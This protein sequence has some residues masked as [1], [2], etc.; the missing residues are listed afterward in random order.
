[1]AGA[2]PVHR[3]RWA[4]SSAGAESSGL[5]S[6]EKSKPTQAEEKMASDDLACSSVFF[7]F[8]ETELDNHSVKL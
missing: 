7:F 6:C 2:V 1:M 8:L 5:W 3:R 4:G